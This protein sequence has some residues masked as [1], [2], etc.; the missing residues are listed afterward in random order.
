M[1]RGAGPVV[2]VIPARYA[3]TRLPGKPLLAETGK[4]LIQHV[5]EQV[6]KCA[7]FDRIVVATDDDRILQAV[8][9]FRSD[10]PGT[11]SSPRP[12][13]HSSSTSTSRSA[14]APASTGS[15]WPPTTTAS[16]RP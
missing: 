6:R 7:G 1:A 11:P 8:K 16:S 13:R 9:A 14:N 15:S 12:A 10:S 3:S 2:A 4:T 5:Y